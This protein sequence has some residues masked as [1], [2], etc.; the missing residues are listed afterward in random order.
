MPLIVSAQFLQVAPIINW[1][2]DRTALVV[3]DGLVRRI[4]GCEYATAIVQIKKIVLKI[5]MAAR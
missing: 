2:D 1:R 3:L 5:F 4:K